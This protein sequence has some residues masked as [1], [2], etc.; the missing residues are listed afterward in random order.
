VKTLLLAALVP[1]TPA[2]ANLT[3]SRLV[4]LNWGTLKSPVPGAQLQLGVSRLRSLAAQ[5]GK[6]SVGDGAD[7]QVSIRLEGVDI[8]PIIES[9]RIFDNP[10]RRRRKLQEILYGA[11][12][13]PSTEGS[14]THS[15]V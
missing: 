6:L 14:F 12:G 10:G 13:L 3:A 8:K 2:L 7:P 15:V 1:Q 9:A 4:Q 5:V 11:L